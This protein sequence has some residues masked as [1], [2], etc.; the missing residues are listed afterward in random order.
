MVSCIKLINNLC[1]IESV[2]SLI[3]GVVKGIITKK[4]MSLW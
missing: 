2:K 1:K 4:T 3:E